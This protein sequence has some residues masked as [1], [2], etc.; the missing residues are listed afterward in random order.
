MT[1]S[2]PPDAT[3]SRRGLMSA[4]DKV[5][6]DAV[7]GTNTGDVT[8]AASTPAGWLTLAGQAL[9]FAAAAASD[10]ADGIVN[11]IAQSFDGAKTFLSA[12]VAAAGLEVQS[13]ALHVTGAPSGLTAGAHAWMGSYNGSSAA[14]LW[15]G[16]AGASPGAS[17]YTVLS[18]S[19]GGAF[20][21]APANNGHTW[22]HNAVAIATLTSTGVHTTAEYVATNTLQLNTGGN[23]RPTANAANRGKLWYS[24]SANGVADT[25][26]VCLKSA[27]DTYSWVTLATG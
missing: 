23:A 10:A 17:N 21:N 25:I 22:S 16:N 24:K 26:E 14:A 12:L 7:S 27:G 20:W 4:A 13:L 11:R 19:G 9:T 3:T 18:F 8:V 15:L 6:I 2:A 1:P 5:K